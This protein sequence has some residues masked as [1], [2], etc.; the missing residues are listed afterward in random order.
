MVTKKKIV[1]IGNGMVGHKFMQAIAKENNDNEYELITFCEES[2]LAYDRMQLSSY[3]NGK[4]AEDLSLVEPGFY[5]DNNIT[6]HI[7]DPRQP[8]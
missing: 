8:H 7:G 1:V 2:R 5:E 6:V 3:F 4:T